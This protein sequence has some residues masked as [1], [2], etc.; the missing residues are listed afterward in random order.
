MANMFLFLVA[1]VALIIVIDNELK[2]EK[3]DK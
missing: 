1:A 3:G 2:H